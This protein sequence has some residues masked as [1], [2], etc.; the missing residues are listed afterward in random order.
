MSIYIETFTGDLQKVLKRLQIEQGKFSLAM[1]YKR[2]DMSEGG[3]NLIIAAPWADRLGKEEA[4]RIVAHALSDGLGTENKQAVTR[5][6]VLPTQD[7]F[8]RAM[9]S[10]YRIS[11]SGPPLA[12]QNSTVAGVS[13]GT[14]FLF[15]SQ[16]SR[17]S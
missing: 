7:E 17:N 10:L 13:I 6:T 1:T 5:V 14:A 12:I 8:V 2:D 9:T 4:T 11:K 16:R 15:Y 3:W